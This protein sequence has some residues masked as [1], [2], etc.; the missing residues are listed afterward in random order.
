[1]I[2]HNLNKQRYLVVY[3]PRQMTC[4]ERE[5]KADALLRKISGG[6]HFAK[7]ARK[8]IQNRA[9]FAWLS[10]QLRRFPYAA[11][12]QYCYNPALVVFYPVCQPVVLL[13]ASIE[14]GHIGSLAPISRRSKGA[15]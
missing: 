2:P 14:V 1:V 7:S 5:N 3:F 4:C 11:H 8:H 15:S 13:G 9:S 10:L 6:E 12:A